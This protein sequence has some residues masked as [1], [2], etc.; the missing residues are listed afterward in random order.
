MRKLNGLTSDEVEALGE[1]FRRSL[2]SSREIFGSYAFR[3][4]T[5]G[6]PDRWNPINKALFEVT[7]VMLAR[8]ERP[9]LCR[10]LDTSE[11]VKEGF[12]KLMEDDIFVASISVGTGQASHLRYRFNAFQKM[13]EAVTR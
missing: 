3:K 5:P 2:N 11:R 1:D 4:R 9:G 12:L 7:T 6:D 8:L 10:I 13:I